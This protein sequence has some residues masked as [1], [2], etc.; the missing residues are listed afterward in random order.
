MG[1]FRGFGP[2]DVEIGQAVGVH[3][4]VEIVEAAA[5]RG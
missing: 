5:K 3:H 4:P 1:R 2:E